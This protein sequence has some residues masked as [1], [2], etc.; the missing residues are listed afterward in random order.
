M[1]TIVVCFVLATF[2]LAACNSSGEKGN[3]SA[4]NA[5]ANTKTEFKVGMHCTDC[6]K[7]IT[8]SVSKLDGIASVNASFKDSFALVSFDSTKVK[9]SAIVLAIQDAGYKVDTFMRR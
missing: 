7:A 6:E 5:I 2:S 1:K 8:K 4:S 9:E 3:A